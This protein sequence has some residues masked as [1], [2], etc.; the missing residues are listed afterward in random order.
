MYTFMNRKGVEGEKEKRGSKRQ[1]GWSHRGEE[2]DG[3]KL[4]RRHQL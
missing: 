1:A 4:R 2:R 3:V